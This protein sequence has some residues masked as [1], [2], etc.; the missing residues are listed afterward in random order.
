MWNSVGAMGAFGGM[1]RLGLLTGMRRSELAGLRWCDVHDDRI[2]LEAH[3][4]KTGVEARSS[5]DCGDA[6]RADGAAED[7]ERARVPVVARRP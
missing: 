4:T 5:A 7:H 6:R 3:G 1:L 2:V